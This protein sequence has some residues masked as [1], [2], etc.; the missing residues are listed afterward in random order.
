MSKINEA[1]L[2]WILESYEFMFLESYMSLKWRAL[3]VEQGAIN[4][5]DFTD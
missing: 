5:S 3:A 4:L 2:N 1:Y